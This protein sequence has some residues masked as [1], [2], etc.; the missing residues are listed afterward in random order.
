[1]VKRSTNL[2][3]SH[4]ARD[5]AS[6]RMRALPALDP[7]YFSVDERTTEDRLRFVRALGERLEYFTASTEGGAPVVLGS[8]GAFAHHPTLSEADIA[9]FIT[10]PDRFVDEEAKWLGRPH[11]VLLLIFLQL[12]RHAQGDMAKLTARHLDFYFREVLRFDRKGPEPDRVMVAFRLSPRIVEV[13]L[14]AGTA[15]DAGR[16]TAGVARI[17]RTEREVTVSQARVEQLRS[18]FVDRR[19][20]RIPDALRRRSTDGFDEALR[21]AL[22]RPASGDPVPPYD[23]RRPVN[24]DF[25]TKVVGPTI[26]FCRERLYLPP[27]A[28]KRMMRLVRHRQVASRNESPVAQ[29]EWREVNQLLERVGREVRGDPSFRLTGPAFDPTAFSENLETAL[30][31][32]WAPPW[33]EVRVADIFTYEAEL[34]RLERHLSMPAHRLGELAELAAELESGV[35]GFIHV[36]RGEH[37]LAEAHRESILS[38]RRD[39]LSQTIA[40]GDRS[41]AGFARIA[42]H[43]LDEVADEEQ[44]HWEELRARFSKILERAQ[45]DVLDSFLSS[46]DN[47]SAPHRFDW[48]DILGVFELAQRI[49]E[50]FVEPVAQ[51]VEWRNL[52]AYED[53]RAAL[54][55]PSVPTRWKTFGR[56]PL[57][58]EAGPAASSMGWGLAS[59]LLQVT[60]GRRRLT[61]TLG[62]GKGFE[63]LEA[64]HGTHRAQQQNA[65]RSPSLFEAWLKD[66]LIVELSQ[67]D[68]WLAVDPARVTFHVGTYHA[69]LGR[70]PPEGLSDPHALRITVVVEPDDGPISA[71][72]SLPEAA[73]RLLLRPKVEDSSG[74]EMTPYMAFRALELSDVH[75]HVAVGPEEAS[76]AHSVAGLSDIRLQAGDRAL[77]PE[78]PF[79]PFGP[80]PVAG[81]R[82]HLAHAE[83]LR[84]RPDRV[85]LGLEWTDLPT[86]PDTGDPLTLDAHY[87][88]YPRS[89]AANRFTSEGFEARL[90]LVDGSRALPLAQRV[91]LFSDSQTK[92][93]PKRAL[94]LDVLGALS[95]TYV[96]PRSSGTIDAQDLRSSPRYLTMELLQDFGHTVFPRLAAR[97]SRALAAA[98]SRG[99]LS[100]EALANYQVEPP[101]TP[102][103]KRLSVGYSTSV[104]VQRRPEPSEGNERWRWDAGPTNGK[105]TLFHAHPFGWALLDPSNPTLF[106]RYEEAGELFIGLASL[107]PPRR[108]SLGFQVAEGTSDPESPISPLTWAYLDGDLWRDLCAEGRLRLDSTGGLV[109]SGIVELD[110]PPVSPSRRMPSNLYWLRIAGPDGRSV[111]DM[112]DIL[113][114]ASFAIFEDRENAETHYERPL[115][116][117]S[118]TRLLERDARIRKIEQP[119]TSFGG[120]PAERPQVFYTRVSE[121]LRHKQRALSPW[122]FER[123]VLEAFPQIYK[124]KCIPATLGPRPGSVTVIVIPDIREARP[125]DELAPRVSA[126]TLRRIAEYLRSRA[127]TGASIEV[128]NP[129][130]VPVRIRLGARFRDSVDVGF[131]L[132]QL[133]RDLVRFLSPWAFDT[134]AEPSLGGKVFESGVLDIAD[135]LDYV[136]FVTNIQLFRIMNGV[137]ELGRDGFVETSRPDQILVSAPDHDIDLISDRGYEQASFTGIDYM[138]IELDFIVA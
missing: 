4:R 79:L 78:K 33:A 7:E 12:L 28:L 96:Y 23:E 73:L 20:T 65:H 58:K 29:A 135:R 77:D 52:Y 104:E 22:G 90:E 72:P 49:V 76:E 48:E 125:S 25:F 109:N 132:R 136:D 61:L 126:A 87:A 83:L 13:R 137:S 108:L 6:Q 69:L 41:R 31:P 92:T 89:E 5:G 91:A 18:V 94:V 86:D 97:K 47:P 110:L 93:E 39:H 66:A 45:L 88:N 131:A 121:R 119:F 117:G 120:R 99:P 81:M 116:E 16:D 35:S 100:E 95:E 111:S 105:D 123:L 46:L 84:A 64:G 98:L 17:Y 15:L 19:V 106:P 8:W 133:N 3:A 129:D 38:D 57:T 42:T 40:R 9:A 82:F 134:K 55:A 101:Y 36:S 24:L 68:G 63:V 1:M 2:T 107:D 85:V 11:F 21:I 130:Y 37:I 26:A 59:P 53:A 138:K 44:F 30:G 50:R 60:S 27:E 67:P 114:Q 103:L 127:P 128:R 54:D 56:R 10:E 118:I 43:L 124:A 70:E 122:D 115:G 62:F 112:V 80:E 74:A 75:L 71:N 34:L 102:T 14:P 113:A 32:W 51:R